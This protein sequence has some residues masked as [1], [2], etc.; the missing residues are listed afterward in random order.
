MAHTDYLEDIGSLNYVAIPDVTFHYTIFGKSTFVN[1]IP[2]ANDNKSK[3]SKILIFTLITQ[4]LSLAKHFFLTDFTLIY[5]VLRNYLPNIQVLITLVC[6]LVIL[7][8][9]MVF[10]DK[11]S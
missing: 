1:I 10:Q 3:F 8:V 11:S 5:S 6:P 2:E 4:I 7:Q 9:K